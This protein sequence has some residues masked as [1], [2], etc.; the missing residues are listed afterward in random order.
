MPPE[1]FAIPGVIGALFGFGVWYDRQVTRWE[2]SGYH[3]GY[4]SFIVALGVAVTIGGIAIL[5]LV[6]TTWNAGFTALLA[7]AASGLPMIAGSVK[8]HISARRRA[9]DSMAAHAMTEAKEALRLLQ[10]GGNAN[11]GA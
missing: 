11:K 5:D 1:Y 2:E 9:V 6:L 3:D 10:G 4:L 8:R 7:F